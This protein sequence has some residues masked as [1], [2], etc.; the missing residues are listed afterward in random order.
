[1][2]YTITANALFSMSA[3]LLVGCSAVRPAADGGSDPEALLAWMGADATL[4]Q[5]ASA[6]AR[7]LYEQAYDH[8]RLKLDANI[9]SAPSGLPL[10]VI[11]DIDET[12]LDNSPYQVA[13]IKRGRVFEP[14]SWRE[15]TGKASAKASPGAI[16]FLRNAAEKRGCEVFY[17]TN[18]G[19]PEQAATL[20]NLRDL[21]F[22]NADAEH[23]LLTDGD[24]DKSARRARVM[25]THRV[26]LIVG[27]QLRDF[28]ERFKA[29]DVNNGHGHLLDLQDSLAKYFILLPNP[30][31]GTWRDAIHG[32]GTDA[33]K[34]GRMRAWFEENGD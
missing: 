10:A 15:W 11:V 6:E 25:A 14:D 5:H 8:A 27:D 34:L 28:S 22:P 7:W 20:K 30:M 17:I 24:S 13:A 33:E 3:A 26:V 16:G 18:R 29:R 19:L 23:L 2:T 32:K 31:Y 9:A 4:W 21:G 12:V 1:M